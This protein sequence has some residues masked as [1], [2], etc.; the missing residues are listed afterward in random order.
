ARIPLRRPRCLSPARAA[1]AHRYRQ[2]ARS[3]H[4]RIAEST[5]F[6]RRSTRRV[7]TLCL[8]STAASR[9]PRTPHIR[10]RRGR[11]GDAALGMGGCRHRIPRP[12]PLSLPSAKHSAHLLSRST[13]PPCVSPLPAAPWPLPRRCA[14]PSPFTLVQPSASTYSAAPLPSSHVLACSLV[15]ARASSFPPSGTY[16]VFPL[17]AISL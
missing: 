4:A 9:R 12:M 15:R 14:R 17:R 3:A 16:F 13:P 6:V 7:R 10:P 8:P 2:R 11:G 1:H 5:T